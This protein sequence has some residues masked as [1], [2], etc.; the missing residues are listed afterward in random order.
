M[1]ILLVFFVINYFGIDVFIKS[2]CDCPIEETKE[3]EHLRRRMQRLC[4]PHVPFIP[5][6]DIG[7]KIDGKV[8][9]TVDGRYTFFRRF[10]NHGTWKTVTDGI[11]RLSFSFSPRECT[12]YFEETHFE[13]MGSFGI[14]DVKE[15]FS[16][17]PGN[18]NIA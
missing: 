5:E 3:A 18:D 16:L 9:E 12:I 14:V 17:L 13:W 8:Y 1:A 7:W 11:S 4:V 2:F 15:N 10:E 6:S